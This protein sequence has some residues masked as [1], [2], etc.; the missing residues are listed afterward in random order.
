M[1]KMEKLLRRKVWK[2]RRRLAIPRQRFSTY[3][4]SDQ[5]DPH[6]LFVAVPSAP[7][8]LCIRFALAAAAGGKKKLLV[9]RRHQL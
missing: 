3:G 8:P 9:S 7:S 2:G 4:P 5:L 1:R 6:L